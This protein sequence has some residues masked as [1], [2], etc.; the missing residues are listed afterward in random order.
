M[1]A[2]IDAA[3]PFFGGLLVSLYAFRV[4]KL[5]GPEASRWMEKYGRAMRIVGPLV[6]L[7]AI[8]L[9]VAGQL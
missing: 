9:F 4:L 8:V 3:I 2:L 7:F 6:M 1:P 5:T